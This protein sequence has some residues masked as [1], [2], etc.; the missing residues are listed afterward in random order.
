MRAR[1]DS[2]DETC[3]HDRLAFFEV[4]LVA[5][6]TSTRCDK[7]ACPSKSEPDVGMC[8]YLFEEVGP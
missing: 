1:G 8:V 2:Q 7:H 4:D 5:V 6:Q 3:P